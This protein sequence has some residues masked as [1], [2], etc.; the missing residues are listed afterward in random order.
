MSLVIKE[1]AELAARSTQLIA[2]LLE[3]GKVVDL[4][5]ETSALLQSGMRVNALLDRVA[6]DLELVPDIVID[7]PE[8]LRETEAILGRLQAVAGDSGEIE[9]ERK[10]LTAP[11]VAVTR[12]L[13]AGYNAPREH[14]KANGIEPGKKKVLAY[15]QEQQRIQAEA[16]AAERLRREQE[17]TEAAQREATARQEAEALVAEAG[18]LQASG[19]EVM[20][21]ALLQSAASS[22]DESRTAAHDAAAALRTRQLVVPAAKAKGV[23]GTWVATLTNLESLILHVAERLKAEDRSLVN[24]LEFNQSAANALA[25]AQKDGMNIP[26]IRAEQ[27][28]GVRVRKG[29]L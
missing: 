11:L 25:K 29:A 13:N 15:H 14:I 8:M 18:K 6:G 3:A 16:E 1:T 2:M 10:L 23:T 17:A 12:M 28:Q 7:S 19:S 22:V 5:P 27:Q 4:D 24:L 9:K 21:Q 20:A 26:G